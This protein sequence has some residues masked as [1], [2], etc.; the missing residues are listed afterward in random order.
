ME[1]ENSLAEMC[2]L[3]FWEALSCW[4]WSQLLFKFQEAG[5]PHLKYSHIIQEPRPHL[6]CSSKLNVHLPFLLPLQASTTALQMAW[7]INLIL[8]CWGCLGLWT[9][10]KLNFL[11]DFFL[12]NLV[13]SA[14]SSSGAGCRPTS[15]SQRSEGCASHLVLY[16]IRNYY[17][18]I[19]TITNIS[20]IKFPSTEHH[21]NRPP[22]NILY[23]STFWWS[24]KKYSCI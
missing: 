24:G 8:Y 14:K 11:W 20:V 7:H 1:S 23:L 3:V 10:R 9:K 15:F 6:R 4:F 2:K 13:V 21:L 5:E 18:C 16:N 17:Q 22:L 19:K 12:L